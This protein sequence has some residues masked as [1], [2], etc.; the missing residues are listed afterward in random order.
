MDTAP[1]ILPSGESFSATVNDSPGEPGAVR[2]SPEPP[3]AFNEGPPREYSPQPWLIWQLA[4]SAFPTGGFAHSAGLEAAWQHGEVPGSTA[5]IHWLEISLRQLELGAL[6]FVNAA[7]QD[8]ERLAD[9]DG[10]CDAFNTS[11]VANRSSRLQGRAFLTAAQ[12]VFKNQPRADPPRFAHLPVVFG[13][14]TQ[15]LGIDLSVAVRL[16]VFL[17]LRGV[18]AAAVR[19]NIIGPLE[20]Q[21]IQFRLSSLAESMSVRG[22]RLTLDDL[23]QTAPLHELWQGAQD[24]LYSR[25]FQS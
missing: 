22:A 5:L 12:R 15:S 3:S 6:P 4:D 25:L 18:V 11:H 7:H 1:R 13:V 19:L 20:A 17:H 24:R 10:L 14:V 2:R 9:I 21:A 8:P 23:A 16:F